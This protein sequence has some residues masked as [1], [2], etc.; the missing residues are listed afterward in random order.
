MI[1]RI[2]G[3]AFLLILGISNLRSHKK[4]LFPKA[5]KLIF[6]KPDNPRSMDTEDLLEFLPED[7]DIENVFQTQTVEESLKLAGKISDTNNLIC[8]TGSLYL[9]GE[10]Q[11][12]LGENVLN[13]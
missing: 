3:A 9:V 5:D 13:P 6:T 11:K 10:V 12:L 2:C 1:V 4:I 8:V 7:C